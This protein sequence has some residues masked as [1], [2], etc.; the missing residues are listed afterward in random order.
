MKNILNSISD[1]IKEKHSK[2]IWKAGEDYVQY[3]G[4]YFDEEEYIEAVK[5]LLDGWLVLGENGIK[6]ENIF[7][8]YSEKKYGILT[9]SGS[10]SNLLMMSALTSKRLYNLPKGTRVITPIAGFPTTI[11][12]IFQVGFFPE[13]VDID[14]DTL[15]LNLD[16][17]E[18][19]AKQGCKVLIFA[20]VLG[21][22]PD[23]D[24]LMSIVN[25]YN[26]IVLEDCCDAL[27]STYDGCALGSFGQFASFSFYPA[28][29]ITMGEGGFVSCKTQEQEI[30]LRSFREWGRGCFCVGKKANLLKNGCCGKRFSN[31]LPSMPDE[32]FDHKYVYDEIGYN[33]KPIDLQA[34]IGLAQLKKLPKIVELR[35]KN[36][37]KLYSIFK[38]YEEYFILPE[39]TKKS[40]PA[41]FAFPLTI[42]N[43]NLFNR[44][45]ITNYL[46][47]HKIQTRPY[48][49]GN[50]MA[51]PAYTD[52]TPGVDFQTNYPNSVKVTTDTFF[53]GT[54]PVIT[55]EQIDY[56]EKIVNKF[57]KKYEK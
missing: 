4:P 50:I 48:F 1:F 43:N 19:K 20:H 46:E 22:P 24:R 40:N 55:D 13:F 49:A 52:I 32:I 41:W 35:I 26:L 10:S 2:K 29:H 30:V 44:F 8:R 37:N 53:L 11:N 51:Q 38:K 34:A 56:I 16:Q 36:Y 33:L 28:H 12:P 7:P 25:E 14:L 39:P 21:N 18:E 54:S 45:D 9:N 42:K 27:G 23:M 5:T 17:V 3:A 6:F 47:E 15:N 57:F 31:W